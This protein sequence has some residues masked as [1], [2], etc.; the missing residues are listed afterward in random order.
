MKSF[1]YFLILVSLLGLAA[2]SGGTATPTTVP[3]AVVQPTTQVIPTAQPAASVSLGK[4]GE[5]APCTVVEMLPSPVP[6]FPQ[7]TS[8]DWVKGNLN[9]RIVLTE[10]SDFQCPGCAAFAPILDQLIRMF[11]DDVQVVFRHYPLSFHPLAPISGQAAEAAGLQ[12]KFWQMHDVLFANQSVWGAMPQA[13]AENWFIEQAG[14][15][16]LDKDRFAA[17][18]R[19]DALVAKV[20]SQLNDA[21]TMGLGGTPSLLINGIYIPFQTIPPANDLAPLIEQVRGVM[22]IA[23]RAYKDCPPVVIETSKQYVATL[24]TTKGDIVIELF[25]D[26]APITVN[27]FVFLA[28]DGWFTNVPFHRVLEGFVAQ[29]GDPSGTGMGNPGYK[30]VNETAAGL[31][32]DRAGV[33]GMA[34]SG[35][36]TNGSQFFITY[37]PTTQLDGGYTIFGQVT[38]ESMAVVSS[39]TFRDP[40]G[41]GTLPNPD[42]ILSVTIQEK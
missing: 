17:D 28:R 16:G 5:P 26:Q 38:E 35:A 34:N 7:V 42:L 33:V 13:D 8:Q 36:D 10:Y 2:C 22:L 31:S 3:T 11:P 29:A 9:G 41:G 18:M 4:L 39:L 1:A 37:G 19:S 12:G 30:F 20:Q 14:A 25:D 40:S 21:I 15:L 24:K 27:S 6:G 32:F 23:P